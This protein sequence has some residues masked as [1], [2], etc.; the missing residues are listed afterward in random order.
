MKT[1]KILGGTA[2]ASLLLALPAF[3]QEAVAPAVEAV[4]EVVPVIDKGDVAWMLVSTMVVIVMTVPG[5][6]LFYGGLVRAK[7]ILSVLTQVF[8]GF[9][10]IAILWVAYGYSLAFAGP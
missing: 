8:L 7:N 5:L 10:M 6:A 3:A 9:S 2:L 4:A 1:S